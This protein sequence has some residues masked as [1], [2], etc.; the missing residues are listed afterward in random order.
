MNAIAAANTIS[1]PRAIDSTSALG[2]LTQNPGLVPLAT[3]LQSGSSSSIRLGQTCRMPLE[4][5]DN[6][7]DTQPV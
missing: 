4:S 7:L 2:L 5:G 1:W 6:Y 3:A